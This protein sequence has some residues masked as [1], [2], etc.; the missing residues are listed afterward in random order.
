MATGSQDP[1]ARRDTLA[2]RSADG[3]I[4]GYL[5][6]S[7]E[8]TV[9]ALSTL[10][11][12]PTQIVPAPGPGKALIA[13]RW[14]YEFAYQEGGYDT[15]ETPNA[16]PYYGTP[17]AA[18]LNGTSPNAA[19]QPLDPSF[20]SNR[21]ADSPIGIGLGPIAIGGGGGQ[22][23]TSPAAFLAARAI[24]EN[25][26]FVIGAL[27]KDPIL[28][29]GIFNA[30]VNPGGAGYAVNDTGTLDTNY[31]TD[32]AATYK[33]TAETAGVVT[34]IE[35]TD[36][37]DGYAVNNPG[38]GMFGFAGGSQPGAGDGMQVDVLDTTPT[39]STLLVTV[40]YRVFTLH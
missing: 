39:T 30:H 17:I 7:V 16:G 11:S 13:R 9:D 37:G 32:H 8:L 18:P 12:A 35:V 22:H 33:V 1:N 40:E 14:L 31:L 23:F 25:Q 38:D 28:F 3:T 5:T 19:G 20:L 2:R 15:G 26:P 29:A 24:I 27:T 21:A 36:P 34:E 4:D 10:F 6:A